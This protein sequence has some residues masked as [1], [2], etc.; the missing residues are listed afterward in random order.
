MKQNKVK[1]SEYREVNRSSIQFANYN[2][3]KITPEAKKKLKDNIKRVGI[4]GGIVWNERTKNLVSGHQRLSIIDEI[5]R[6]NPDTQEND[7]LVRVEVVDFDEKTEKEQNLFMNNRNVQGE[8]DFDELRN[9]IADIDYTLAGLTDFDLNML[10][11]GEIEEYDFSHSFS[12]KEEAKDEEVNALYEATKGGEENT[13]V[14]R[15]A[16]FYE[17]SKENQIIRHNEV[18][19]IKD[20]INN[21][22]NVE[23]DNGALSYVVLSFKSPSA[24]A[25]FMETY[26]YNFE[27]R[28]IDG[29]EFMNRVEFGFDP[30]A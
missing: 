7:Y 5:N 28:Y 20:R 23:K 13:K 24:R 14:D 26:G 21:Q 8:F 2:P 9:M 18:Q 11:I 19:K 1:Q 6:Y 16:D 17:D 15:S 12:I 30:D 10:G 3:R 4:L 25:N 22:N 29:E 27:D